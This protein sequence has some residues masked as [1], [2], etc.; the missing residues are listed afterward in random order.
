M[1]K[2][3]DPANS[4]KPSAILLSDYPKLSAPQLTTHIVITPTR[5]TTVATAPTMLNS[6]N[7]NTDKWASSRPLASE[8]IPKWIR[9]PT[10]SPNSQTSSVG[11]GEEEVKKK[12]RLYTAGSFIGGMVVIIIAIVMTT[13]GVKSYKGLRSRNYNYLRREEGFSL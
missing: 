7:N 8:T 3:V 4:T 2:D 5:P 9:V 11:Q 10:E 12:A 1:L 13:F 6:T